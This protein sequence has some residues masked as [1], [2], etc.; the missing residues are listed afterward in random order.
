MGTFTKN[1][2]LKINLLGIS[3][4][5]AT[6]FGMLFS[7]TTVSITT[8]ILHRMADRKIAVV[9]VNQRRNKYLLKVY[10]KLY[11]RQ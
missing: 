7:W 10:L 4:F 3:F 11:C 8:I 1:R 6:L 9:I 5:A 2:F